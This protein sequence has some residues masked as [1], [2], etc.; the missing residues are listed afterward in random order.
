MDENRAANVLAEP[1]RDP[2]NLLPRT[3]ASE[4]AAQ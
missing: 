1:A 3:D 2:A 4:V